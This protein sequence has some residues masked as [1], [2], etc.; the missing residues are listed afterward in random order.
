MADKF[1]DRPV[2][3]AGDAAHVWVPYAGYGMNAGIAD[4][5]NLS[6]LLAA[7]LNGLGA[8]GHSRP[9]YEA[10]RL[11]ITDQVSRFPM[12]HA[13]VEIRR[14]G[15]VPSAIE[16]AGPRGERA[17]TEVERLAYEINVQQYACAGLNFGAYYDRSP[18]IAYDGSR[19]PPYTMASYVPST[20]PCCRT[21]HFWVPDGTSLYDVMGSEFT[22]LRLDATID[23]APLVAAA[24]RRAVPLTVGCCNNR[25]HHDG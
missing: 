2:F 7:H 23:T 1:R 9:A 14:R 17:R 24:E 25:Q 19:H 5:T 11:P 16:E 10:E 20:V 13:A 4:A 12:S 3:I 6:W 15:A 22:L 8:G 21:P 18:I